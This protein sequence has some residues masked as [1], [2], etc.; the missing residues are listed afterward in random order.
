MH[1]FFVQTNAFWYT[2]DLF[3]V[4]QQADPSRGWFRNLP[5]LVFLPS[6]A[7]L[8]PTKRKHI[9]CRLYQ[10]KRYQHADMPNAH[11][12]PTYSIDALPSLSTATAPSPAGRRPSVLP[13][14][15]TLSHPITTSPC[16]L[17][18]FLQSAPKI[19]LPHEGISRGGDGTQ[20]DGGDGELHYYYAKI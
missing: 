19:N 5:H 17:L 10:T 16:A 12:I 1:I 7:Q 14:L 15:L 2:R 8:A 13:A 3:V 20:K 9:M 18:L 6:L 4:W 11:I